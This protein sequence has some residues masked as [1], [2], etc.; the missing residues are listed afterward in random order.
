MNHLPRGFNAPE[1]FDSGSTDS[2]AWVWIEH[3]SSGHPSSGRI[4]DYAAV[5]RCLGR[6]GGR[7]S[8]RAP[9]AEWL[10]S[11]CT[12]EWVSAAEQAIGLL[13][14]LVDLPLA[15]LAYPPLVAADTLR[16]WE[17]RESLLEQL[18][19]FPRTLCHN[20][21]FPRN[22]FVQSPH[23]ARESVTAVDWSLIGLGALGED[24]APL[25]VEPKYE[26]RYVL[27]KTI[28]DR[29]L[30]GARDAK[31]PVRE[32]DVRFAYVTT[33]ALRYVVG[34]LPFVLDIA[35][36]RETGCDDA[37]VRE[38]FAGVGRSNGFILDLAARAG[39]SARCW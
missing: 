24:I 13:P 31:I 7:F 1:C 20:D 28:L 6:F 30:A 19:A 8:D 25:I 34:T 3:V 14:S 21:A 38:A 29:Y 18:E 33:A 23:G 5:A 27:D 22:L 17:Q 26:S 15:E 9:S 32:R 10:L 37:A 12:R 35:R 16:L 36:D 4:G 2:V 39:V 11:D